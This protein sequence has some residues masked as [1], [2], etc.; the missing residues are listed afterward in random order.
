MF[1]DLYNF[2]QAEKKKLEPQVFFKNKILKFKIKT[3]SQNQH[4]T[5]TR[6]NHAWK[7]VAE[8]SFRIMSLLMCTDFKALLLLL[9][10]L[11][12]DRFGLGFFGHV[13]Q[14]LLIYALYQSSRAPETC[15]FLLCAFLAGAGANVETANNR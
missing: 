6:V 10:L 3:K 11:S 15:S 5:P 7:R 4:T 9:L 1:Y 2:K 13:C 12:C 14:V 8:C